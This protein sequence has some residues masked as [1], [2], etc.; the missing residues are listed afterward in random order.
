MKYEI[1]DESGEVIN[2]IL[3]DDEFMQDQYPDGNYRVVEE[4]EQDTAESELEPR[5]PR[6]LTR[7]AFRN[8]MTLAE[9]TA[10]YEAAAGSAMVRVWLDDLAVAEEINLDDPSTVEGLKALEAA[11]L[12]AEGRAAE[13]LA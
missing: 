13:I 10:I 9:K 6:L 12:L 3:A 8:L 2:V 11:G 1:F 7:L 4:V 5:P